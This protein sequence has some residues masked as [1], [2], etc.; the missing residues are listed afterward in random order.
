M[1]Y[2]RKSSTYYINTYFQYKNRELHLNSFNQS[3][4][5]TARTAL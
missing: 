1:N 2:N 5:K 3:F 4:M